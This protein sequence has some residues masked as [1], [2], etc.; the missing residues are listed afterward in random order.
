MGAEAAVLQASVM[1][2]PIYL[3]MGYREVTRYPWFVE[4]P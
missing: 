1:G 3:K 4:I 2:E